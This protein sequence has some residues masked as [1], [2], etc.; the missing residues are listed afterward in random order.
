[1]VERPLVLKQPTLGLQL[2]PW[3]TAGVAPSPS[4][5]TTRW[6]GMMMG[7]GLA[8]MISPIARAGTPVPL[9]LAS[10]P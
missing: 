4:L 9:S 5:A 10:S 1:M 8:A 3:F 2:A 6:H 7:T